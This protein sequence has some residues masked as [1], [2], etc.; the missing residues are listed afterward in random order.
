MS[1]STTDTRWR[2]FIARDKGADGR[3]V[4]AVRST[5]IYCRPSCPARHP[6]PENVTFYSTPDEARQHG[7]RACLRCSPDAPPQN[8]SREIVAQVCGYIDA[9]EETPQ[10]E[11]LARQAGV[12]SSHLQRIFKSILGISPK[13]YAATRRMQRFKQRLR[14]GEG[15]TSALYAAGFGSSSRLYENG[16]AHLGMTPADFRRAG[17]GAQLTFTTVPTLLGRMLVACTPRGVC[18]VRFGDSD[19]GLEKTLR[20]DYHRAHVTRDEDSL[21]PVVKKIVAHLDRGTALD[22]IAYDVRATAFQRRVWKAL[23]LI[24]YG[25]TRTYGEIA[26]SLGAPGAARAVGRACGSNQVAVIIPCHRAVAKDANSGGYRW[27]M[28]RK[29]VL[30]QQERRIAQKPKRQIA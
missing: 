7:Y 25:Q 17:S 4:V 13:E 27:G 22:G 9:Q 1:I 30:L 14:T 29:Q 2:S 21:R 26:A 5:K 3:F 28:Q 18:E 6:K 10:L 16:S 19:A 23:S 11:S 15:V 20:Q 8:R 12:S 24:P